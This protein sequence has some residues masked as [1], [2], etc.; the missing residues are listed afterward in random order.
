MV[1]TVEEVAAE[2][3]SLLGD[4]SGRVFTTALAIK[5]FQRAYYYLRAAML[6]DQIPQLVQV[7][8]YTVPAGTLELS[9]ANIG[10]SNFGELIGIDER[11]PATTEDWV[12]LVEGD[13]NNGRQASSLGVFEWRGDGFFFFGSNTSREIR[14]RY[15]DTGVAPAA[16]S[17]GIDSALPFLSYYGA[18]AVGPSKGYDDAEIQRMRAL[19]LGPRLDGSGGFLYELLQPMVRASQRVQRQPRPYGAGTYT[20]RRLRAKPYIAAPPATQGVEQVLTVSGAVD[21]VNDIFTLSQFPQD[22]DLYVNGLLQ[23][24]GVA[25]ELNGTVV[26]FYP[27]Y[28]P[29]PGALLR[30][31]ASI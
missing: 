7:V 10:I 30:A 2:I 23:Y 18:S 28:I 21:G 13:L 27:E 26:T 1:P 4:E 24:P 11:S 25:Y 29:G 12:P 5:G 8:T 22:L 3:Q 19:A 15:Y 31:K 6:K 14:V 17:I 20:W 16:G 9:P